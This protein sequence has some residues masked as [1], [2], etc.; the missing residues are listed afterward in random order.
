M[1]KEA[2]VCRHAASLAKEFVWR[3]QE[4]IAKREEIHC[5]VKAGGLQGHWEL[6]GAQHAPLKTQGVTF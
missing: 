3:V 5:I 4:K 2:A 1:V 6:R